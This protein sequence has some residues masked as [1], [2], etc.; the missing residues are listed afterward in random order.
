LSSFKIESRIPLHISK[1]EAE[2]IKN[3]LAVASDIVI[4]THHR[5]DGDAM[6]SSL[7]LFHFLE[8]MGHRVKVIVPSIYPD[9]LFWL[10]GC[11]QVIN[12][13]SNSKSCENLIQNSSLVF[14]LDFNWLNRADKLENSLRNCKAKKILIDHH[15][16]PE[17]VFDVVVSYQDVSSTSE[18]IV[19]LIMGLDEVSKIDSNIAYC[20]YCGIMTDTNSFRFSSMKARTHRIVAGLMDAGAKNYIIHEMVFDNAQESRLRLL[21]HALSEKLVVLPEYRTAYISLT[22]KELNEYNYQQGDTEGF[23]NMALGIKGIM[24]AVFF[25]E[26][27]GII[28]ISFRSKGDFSVQELSSRFFNGGGHKNASGGTSNDSM[29]NTLNRFLEILPLYKSQLNSL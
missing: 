3:L 18:L 15:L 13:E 20:L 23:V 29:E 4:V 2:A 8:K 5:P 28:K 10:P 12:Y 9:F 1:E 7:G 24:L 26:K 17:D 19:D 25:S 11:D 6:G 27:S 16:H 21:G 14:C 22:E